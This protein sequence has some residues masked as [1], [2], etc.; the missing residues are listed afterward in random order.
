MRPG[1]DGQPF[2]LQTSIKHIADEDIILSDRVGGADPKFGIKA[3][4]R[5]AH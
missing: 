2:T 1:Y 5:P 4:P 3:Q